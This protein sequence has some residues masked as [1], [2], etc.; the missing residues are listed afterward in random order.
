LPYAI[1]PPRRSEA[2]ATARNAISLKDYAVPGKEGG[3]RGG[4][5]SREKLNEY[6]REIEQLQ[7]MLLHKKN[8]FIKQNIPGYM[9]TEAQERPG[10]SQGGYV[11]G[12]EVVEGDHPANDTVPAMLSPGEIV[13]P[14]SLVEASD[15]EILNFIKKHRK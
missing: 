5:S 11:G 12:G 3:G 7:K 14:K 6:E 13:I 4:G 9:P 15:E 10:M 8:M 1:Q 2:V